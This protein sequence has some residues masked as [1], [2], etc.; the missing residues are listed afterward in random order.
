M[1]FSNIAKIAASTAL[2]VVSVASADSIVGSKHDMTVG[3]Y[4]APGDTTGEVCVYCH[5]PHNA[6]DAGVALWNRFDSAATYDTYDTAGSWSLDATTFALGGSS[7]T[8]LGCHDGTV[9][10]DRVANAPGAQ[11]GPLTQIC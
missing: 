8:C 3:S 4:A 6:V 7:L 9:A 11:T 1:R 10:I 2:L 5:T